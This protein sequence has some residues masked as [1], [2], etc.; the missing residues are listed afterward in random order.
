MDF[1]R[2]IAEKKLPVIPA[3]PCPPRRHEVTQGV[4]FGLPHMEVSLSMTGQDNPPTVF[5]SYSQDNPEHKRWEKLL[6]PALRRGRRALF[7]KQNAEFVSNARR[8]EHEPV[9]PPRGFTI[10]LARVAKRRRCV[11]PLGIVPF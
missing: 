11:I 3:P 4:N 1:R 2:L 10:D 7:L 6:A 5:I 8:R 9:A